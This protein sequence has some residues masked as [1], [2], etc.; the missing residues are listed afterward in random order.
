ML[1][2]SHENTEEIIEIN[3]ISERR[4]NHVKRAGNPMW[5]DALTY[6]RSVQIEHGVSED[7]FESI[8]LCD[9]SGRNIHCSVSD[10]SLRSG[11][12]LPAEN[13]LMVLTTTR[14]AATLNV[15]SFFKTDDSLVFGC[16]GLDQCWISRLEQEV[17][18]W[19]DFYLVNW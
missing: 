18:L 9:L 15:K 4:I 14:S 13:I 6:Y 5:E 2:R 8:T 12:N 3:S 17:E 1:F 11:A 19:Q 10:G 16:A 7:D